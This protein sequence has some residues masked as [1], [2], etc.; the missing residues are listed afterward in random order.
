MQWKLPPKV[1]SDELVEGV[2]KNN[3]PVDYVVFPDEGHGFTG[4]ANRITAQ[5]AYLKFLDQHVRSEP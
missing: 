2:R 3:V 4:R 5:D 1:E